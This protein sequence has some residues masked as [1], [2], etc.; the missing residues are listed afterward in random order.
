[1]SVS[2]IQKP[3]LRFLFLF[4]GGLP[5]IC[6]SDCVSFSAHRDQQRGSDA[7]EQELT[8]SCELPCGC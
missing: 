7:L 3:L 1:V 4:Y 2:S 8:T 5:I 6:M